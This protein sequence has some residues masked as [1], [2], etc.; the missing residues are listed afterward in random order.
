M[1]RQMSQRWIDDS[2]DVASQR[3]GVDTGQLLPALNELSGSGAA[4]W[5]WAQLGDRAAITRDDDA[6]TALHTIQHFSSPVAEVAHSNRIHVCIVSPVRHRVLC[7]L[8][9][10]GSGS[11]VVTLASR[12]GAES[13]AGFT[14]AAQL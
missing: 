5:Q 9:G 8:A 4:A 6:F 10:V 7:P 14:R 3:I 13:D 12:L 11:P 2:V 1:P